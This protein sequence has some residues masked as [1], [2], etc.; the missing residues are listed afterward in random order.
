MWSANEGTSY[1]YF[2][3]EYTKSYLYAYLGDG[4]TYNSIHSNSFSNDDNWHHYAITVNSNGNVKFYY[5][6]TYKGGGTATKTETSFTF[7]ISSDDYR[8]LTGYID[9]VRIYSTALTSARI[10]QH[11]AEGLLNHLLTQNN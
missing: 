7:Q 9:N 5:D 10:Q 2:L 6:G 8:R 4:A 11:Y 3:M 1:K